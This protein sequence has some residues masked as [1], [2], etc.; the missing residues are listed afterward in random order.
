MILALAACVAP[1]DVATWAPA[2]G[3]TAWS[4]ESGDPIAVPDAL[5]SLDWLGEPSAWRWSNAAS[6]ADA[7][8]LGVGNGIVFALVGL[9]GPNTLSNAI[10]PGYDADA[11]AGFYSDTALALARDGVELVAT[12]TRV[13]RPRGTAVARASIA[14]G[15]LTLGTTDVAPPG[16]ASI[17]RHVTVGNTGTAD[18]AGLTLVGA[19]SVEVRGGRTLRASCDARAVPALAPGAEWSTTCRYAFSRDG[20]FVE[21]TDAVEALAASRDVTG[22]LLARAA[23]LDLPDEKVADLYEG[24]VIT[25]HVQTSASGLVSPMNRYTRGWLRDTEGPARLYLRAGLFEEVDAMLDGTLRVQVSEGAISNSFPLEA[26]I[27]LDDIALP[28]DPDAFWA[29]VPFMAGRE[30]VEAPSF[31]ILVQAQLDAFSGGAPDAQRLAWLRACL[32]RQEVGEAG[33]FPFS[34]DETFR[35]PL[36]AALGEGLPEEVGWSANSAFLYDA[37]AA[38]LGEPGIG[39]DPFWA[40]GY[41]APVARYAD[42]APTD[43]P[44]EDVALQPIWWGDT[45]A[46]AEENLA[47]SLA[48]LLREDGTLRSTLA[49]TAEDT[50]MTTGMVPGYLLQNVARVHRDEEALAFA[51]LDLGA[52]PSGHFEELHGPDGRPLDVTHTTDGLGADVPARY[53]PWEGGDVV[54]ALLDYLYGLEPDAAGAALTLAPHLP[55]GWPTSAAEGLRMGNTYFDLRLSGY[56]EGQVLSLARDPGATWRTRIVLHGDHPFARLWIA[57]EPVAV[58]GAVVSTEVA[59]AGGELVIVGEYAP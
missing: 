22:A 21:D 58:S 41:W 25:A 54:A 39:A 18:A 38:R 45:S 59:W 2:S 49:G 53:R 12:D 26:D 4:A 3:F 32:L 47:T 14:Y 30:P 9:D 11:D 56:A 36:A 13:Q 37:A 23:T 7:G 20:S 16:V 1:P 27:P 51:A 33:L 52:T 10:G 55:P 40:D 6:R 8:A 57:G 44:F 42:L 35:Y 46:R 34:G 19:D 29:S 15:D 43:A 31:P 17:V 5:G 24:M 48:V 28:D 50:P